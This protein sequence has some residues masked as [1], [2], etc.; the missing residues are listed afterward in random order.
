[1][2]QTQRVVRWPVWK[3]GEAFGPPGSTPDCPAIWSASWMPPGPSKPSVPGPI[4]GRIASAPTSLLFSR[5]R[6]DDEEPG[7]SSCPSRPRCLLVAPR[8][9]LPHLH[10]ALARWCSPPPGR[11]VRSSARAGRAASQQEGRRMGHGK[12]CP[13]SY[14]VS[15]D[16]SRTCRWSSASRRASCRSRPP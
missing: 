3:A 16:P 9:P 1:M 14:H 12:T 7:C 8:T 11:L 4:P 13:S 15:R 5:A 10:R 2:G 6:R